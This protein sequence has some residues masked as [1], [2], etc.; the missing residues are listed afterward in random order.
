MVFKSVIPPTHNTGMTS[1]SSYSRKPSVIY[2]PHNS[3]A[4]YQTWA[5]NITWSDG[6][7]LSDAVT[8]KSMAEMSQAER[9][10]GTVTQED[11]DRV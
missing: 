2:C 3:V 4:A 5:D 7:K 9:D 8:I 10:M 1:N 11:I 6:Y